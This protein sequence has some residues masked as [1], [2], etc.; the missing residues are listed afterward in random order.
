MQLQDETIC[1]NDN[2]QVDA[3]IPSGV[4]YSWSPTNGVSNPNIANPSFSPNSSTTY[5]VTIGDVCGDTTVDD[6]IL[7]VLPNQTPTFNVVSQICEGGSLTSLPT[8][9]LDT[10][11][12]RI[13]GIPA[14]SSAPSVLANTAHSRYKIRLPR[15]GAFSRK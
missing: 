4:T 9:S 7:T 11:K 13:N 10:L 8:T 3:T 2:I 1:E 15:I 12:A 5:T 14:P 6:F